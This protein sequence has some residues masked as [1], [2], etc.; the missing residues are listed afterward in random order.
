M[1]DSSYF[2]FCLQNNQRLALNQSS[3]LLETITHWTI[4]LESRVQN[5]VL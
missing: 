3:A 5:I 4:T 2:L 1:Y